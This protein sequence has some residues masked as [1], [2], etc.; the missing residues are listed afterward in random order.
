GTESPGDTA[1]VDGTQSPGNTVPTDG[2]GSV[3]GTA[4]ADGRAPADGTQSP[5]NTVPTDGTESPGDTALVDGTQSP[6]N[7]VPTDGAGSVDGSAPYGGLGSQRPPHRTGTAVLL[8]NDAGRY[9]LHLRDN[10]PG[11][12]HPGTWS[13]IGGRPEGEESLE[14]AIG[15]ELREEAG[16]TLPGLRRYTVVPGTGPGGVPQG[17]IQVFLG[18]WNGDADALPITEGVMF[19]W[20]DAA[21]IDRLVMCPWTADVV[22]QHDRERR[23]TANGHRDRPS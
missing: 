16:L 4:P 9:L 11:I 23:R 14:E 17:E 7:T 10:I 19:R 15:R 6:G 22:R 1:L 13:L 12:C 18:R 3:D 5:G 20:F 8:V 21:M 2:A